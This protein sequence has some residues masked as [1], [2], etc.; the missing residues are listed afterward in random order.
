MHTIYTPETRPSL[1]QIEKWAALG[2]GL[3]LLT[4]GVT[5]RSRV[6]IGI[7]I[8]SSP[9]VY[10]GLTGQWPGFLTNGQDTRQVLGGARGIHVRDAI[11]LERPIEDV[12]RYWRQLE[13]LPCFMSH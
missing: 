3:F 2:A 8:A 10:R 4:Y 13:N 9:L 6:G 7:A 12:Y 1:T 5:R 11:R